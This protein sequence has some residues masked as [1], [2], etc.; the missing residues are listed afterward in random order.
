MAGTDEEL[1]YVSETGMDHVT[2]VL[3]M[4]RFV[5]SPWVAMRLFNFLYQIHQPGV[6]YL[7][8]YEH[9]ASRV[10]NWSHCQTADSRRQEQ[11]LPGGT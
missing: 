2:Y 5:S 7:R 8:A 9:A 11:L 6:Y 1:R 4:Y 3:I 10:F